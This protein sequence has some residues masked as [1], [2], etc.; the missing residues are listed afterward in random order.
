MQKQLATAALPAG[1]AESAAFSVLVALSFS[2]LLND[3]MQSLLP[4]L[5]PM[6]KASL[7][8]DFGQVGLITLAFQ[9]TASV[10]QPVV[11]IVTDRRCPSRWPSAWRR[12]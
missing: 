7:A 6:L 2:H 10:L 8:L 3:T 4:A 12:R 9:L 5:Y 11:G 1:A